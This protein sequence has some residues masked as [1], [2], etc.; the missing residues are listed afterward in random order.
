MLTCEGDGNG[1][2]ETGG[3]CEVITPWQPDEENEILH[4]SGDGDECS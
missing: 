4:S 1:K 3:N 2:N